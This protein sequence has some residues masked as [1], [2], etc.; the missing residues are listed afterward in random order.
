ML[1]FV[2]Y[3]PLF[4][5]RKARVI[6]CFLLNQH[7]TEM[8]WVIFLS[9][10]N[11]RILFLAVNVVDVLKLATLGT[12]HIFMLLNEIFKGMSSTLPIMSSLAV[13]QFKMFLFRQALG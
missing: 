12:R 7:K 10:N 13:K 2:S 3:S 4:R 9:Q 5:L 1:S 11:L 6:V 8:L